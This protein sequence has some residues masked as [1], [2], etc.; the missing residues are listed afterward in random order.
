MQLKVTVELMN[1]KSVP[2][3]RGEIIGDFTPDAS[4]PVSIKMGSILDAV[5]KQIL[6]DSK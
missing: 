2:V 4:T 5:E 1:G 3:A 6:E